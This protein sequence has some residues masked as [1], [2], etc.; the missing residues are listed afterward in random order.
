[1]KKTRLAVCAAL[2]VTGSASAVVDIRE[3]QNNSKAHIIVFNAEN[4]SNS[5]YLAPNSKTDTGNGLWISQKEGIK[6]RL[7]IAQAKAVVWDKDFRIWAS[8]EVDTGC[9][10]AGLGAGQVQITVGGSTPTKK[11]GVRALLEVSAMQRVRLVINADCS[12]EFAKI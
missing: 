4:P 2:A 7:F 11:S 5:F 1:M 3:I 10:P 6:S 9:A 8:D 12:I